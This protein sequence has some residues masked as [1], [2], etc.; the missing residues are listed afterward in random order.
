MKA[1]EKYLERGMPMYAFVIALLCLLSAY[2]T[3]G[4]NWVLTIVH[5]L[6]FVVVSILGIYRVR[7]KANSA[8]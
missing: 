3:W 6:G 5:L 2:M 1:Q 4:E 7:R 8:H